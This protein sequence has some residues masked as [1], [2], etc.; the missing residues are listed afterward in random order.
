MAFPIPVYPKTPVQLF[1]IAPNTLITKGTVKFSPSNAINVGVYVGR[2]I[3]CVVDRSV[4]PPQFYQATQWPLYTLGWFNESLN[5][6]S[7]TTAS[8]YKEIWFV[9]NY[10]LSCTNALLY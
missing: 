10:V 6:A 5:M 1:Q 3:V 8:Q 4:S 7:F 2:V 9:S